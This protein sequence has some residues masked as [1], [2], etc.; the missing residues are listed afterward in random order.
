ML[1]ITTA[2]TCV[3]HRNATGCAASGCL[4]VTFWPAFH[5]SDCFELDTRARTQKKAQRVI[6]SG[7]HAHFIKKWPTWC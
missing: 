6:F 7:L 3:N 2:Q 1:Q 5:H 4:Y